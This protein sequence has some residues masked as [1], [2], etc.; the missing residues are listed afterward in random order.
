LLA[1]D[2]GGSYVEAAE[3]AGRRG[4]EAVSRLVSR[5]DREGIAAIE[6]RHGGGPP[7]ACAVACAEAERER[8]P[9]E[10]RRE[11]EPGRDGAAN[12]SL[13]AL[14]RALREAP[15]GLP[16]AGTRTVRKVLE[17]AGFDRRRK[18]RGWCEAGVAERKRGGEVAAVVDP[19]ARAEKS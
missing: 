14:R 16:G 6:A 13:A 15:D 5:F 2:D 10:A 7:V 3:A 18:D 8:I 12:R 19:D 4:G 9:A 17:G 11:P 1:V